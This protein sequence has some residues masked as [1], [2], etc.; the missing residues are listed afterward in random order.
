M[1]MLTISACWGSACVSS[2]CV[3]AVTA[4]WPW[5]PIRVD[6]RRKIGSPVFWSTKRMF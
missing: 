1:I 5:R 2:S 4:A 6:S 3:S